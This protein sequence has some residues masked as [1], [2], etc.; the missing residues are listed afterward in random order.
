MSITYQDLLSGDAAVI[1]ESECSRKVTLIKRPAGGGIPVVVLSW[2]KLSMLYLTGA[3]AAE[4][5]AKGFAPVG[6]A[7]RPFVY[8]TETRKG[9]PRWHQIT[10]M[11][12][13][14]YG[15]M[16][17]LGYDAAEGYCTGVVYA[18]GEAGGLSCRTPQQVVRESCILAIARVLSRYE[19]PSDIGHGQALTQALD[20]LVEDAVAHTN[21]DAYTP[22][23]NPAFMHGVKLTTLEAARE[24]TP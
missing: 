7:G 11:N 9:Q 22:L 14:R 8:V 10:F 2:L 16:A 3:E 6:E 17:A 15:W 21:R 5:T 1:P 12:F 20:F 18:N 24:E 4:L 23:T 19:V 13:R